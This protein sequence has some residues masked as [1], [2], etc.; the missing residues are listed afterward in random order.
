VKIVYEGAEYEFDFDKIRVKQGVKIERYTG[1]T[2]TEWSEQL[3]QGASMLAL[4][5]V[6]WLVLFEGKGAID[7]ADFE[8]KAFGEALSAA[9]EAQE[10]AAKAAGDAAADV[11]ADPT[12]PLPSARGSLMPSPRDLPS[13]LTG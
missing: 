4:Q 9:G 12:P 2:L 8:V 11:P 10:A 13:S 1:M 3:S 7:D 5:A 6:G